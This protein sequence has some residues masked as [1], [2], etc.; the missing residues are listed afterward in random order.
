MNANCTH[1]AFA[2]AAHAWTCTL[3]SVYGPKSADAAVWT[4]SLTAP[5]RKAPARVKKG[6]VR[7]GAFP[8][9]RLRTRA[10]SDNDW[11]VA[12][13]AGCGYAQ[14]LK[15][16]LQEFNDVN[17]A[18][19]DAKNIPRQATVFNPTTAFGNWGWN[20]NREWPKLVLDEYQAALEQIGASTDSRQWDTTRPSTRKI[21]HKVENTAK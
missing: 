6:I 5:F 2:P 14:L 21:G 8:K 1:V 17:I 9:H 15:M 3:K 19:W 4:A 18:G 11:N 7:R 12:K 10:L 13:T 20:P 16:S